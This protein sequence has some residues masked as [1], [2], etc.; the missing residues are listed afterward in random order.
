M[1]TS[2]DKQISGIAKQLETAIL[3]GGCFWCLE[4]VFSELAGVH[5]VRS[6]YCGGHIESPD[7]ASVCTGQTGHAEVVRIRF[8]PEALSFR[9]VLEVFFAIHDPTTLDRQGNDVGSQYRSVI[10][11]TTPS[12]RDE[13]TGH[14]QAL[15]RAGVFDAP[16]VTAIEAAQPFWPAEAVH[17]DY[18]ARHPQQPYCQY[19]VA[20]KLAKF[21]HLFATLRRSV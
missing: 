17:D 7:Y 2:S 5:E 13:A 8:D 1:D 21:R 9:Q 15:T 11:A 10:F 14:V 4:A 12:Q 6:G 3:G 20:P 18:Y 19:V 16:V